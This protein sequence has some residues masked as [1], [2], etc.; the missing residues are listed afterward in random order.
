[1]IKTITLIYYNNDGKE[2]IN[3]K[4]NTGYSIE[5]HL[6]KDDKGK[7]LMKLKFYKISSEDSF[8]PMTVNL[9]FGKMLDTI[10]Y[11]LSIP[12]FKAGTNINVAVPSSLQK[13]V[14]EDI[15]CKGLPVIS[16]DTG[17]SWQPV[18]AYD[19]TNIVF[20]QNKEKNK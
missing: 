18:P 16:S 8:A 1:V 9:Y 10:N 11:Y 20:P 13:K 7:L 17:I 5:D 2:L 14:N 4:R 19:L 3:I 15:C 12:K 6:S